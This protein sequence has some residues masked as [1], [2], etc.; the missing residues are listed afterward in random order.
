MR[1]IGATCFVMLVISISAFAD[2][3][4]PATVKKLAEG[5]GEATIKGDYAKVIDSTHD[6]VVKSLG[7]RAEAIKT[8]ESAMKTLMSRGITIKSYTVGQPGE[9]LTEGDNTF[10]VIPTSVEMTIPKGKVVG[11]SYLL[12]ISPDAGKT[13][14]FAEGAA[15]DTQAGRDLLPKFPAKLKLPEKQNPQII[16]D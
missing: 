16:K 7:G 3:P 5:I 6:N 13:W 4:K 10:V 8:T 14:K 9:F 15:L 1:R 11:K 2:E 12:G